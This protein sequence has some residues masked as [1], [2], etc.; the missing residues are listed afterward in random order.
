MCQKRLDMHIAGQRVHQ[1]LYYTNR[2]LSEKEPQKCVTIIYDKM[3]HSK[4][5]SP[6]FSHKSKHMDLFMKLPISMTGMIVY[7]HGDIRYAHYRLDIFPSDLNHTLGSITKLLRD[8]ELPP[9]H[10]SRE[11]FLASL[12]TALL[13]GSKMCTSSLPPQVAEQV[14]TKPLPLVLNLQ[15]DNATRDNKNRFVFV[16]CSLLTY[17]GVFQE[18]YI[19][20]LIVGHRHDDNDAFFGRWSYKLRGTDYPTLP[21]LM[22]S[23]IDIESCL[24]IRHLIEE[25]PDFKKFVEGYLCTRCD[26]LT[27]HTNAKQFKFYRNA[28]CWLLIQ[29]K[30]LCTNNKWLP[31]EGGGIWL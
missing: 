1:E 16:F 29:Y 30:L 10:S 18:V 21:L 22:K 19:N 31:K 17:Y 28:N 27:G 9:M 24:V 12:F 7:G 26:A 13:V 6:H 14:P 3:D 15:L 2:F 20:F 5:S 4:T 8:L 23:F 25:V 11:L